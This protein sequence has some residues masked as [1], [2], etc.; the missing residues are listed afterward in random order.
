MGIGYF[1]Y[2]KIQLERGLGDEGKG[3]WM[4]CRCFSH[5]FQ[6]VPIVFVL[7][8]SLLKGLGHAILNNFV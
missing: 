4:M 8:A 5:S 6:S 3:K 7:S 2:I 1:Q